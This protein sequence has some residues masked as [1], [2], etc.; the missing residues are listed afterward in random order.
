MERVIGT[1]GVK[2]LE[3]VN[4]VR[5]KWRVRWDAR[6][7]E[8]GSV[9]YMEEE[10]RY[11]PSREEIKAMIL[12][13]HDRC[14]EESILCGFVNDGVPVWLSRENQFNY[15]AACDL[16]FQSGGK[17][18]PVTFKF[19]TDDDPVY[20]EFNTLGELMDFHVRA[21]AHIQSALSD[22]WRRKD[23]LD[24]SPYGC[25]DD[26]PLNAGRP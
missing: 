23:A 5:D 16:A 11:K 25:Q 12:R 17:T 3:R 4:P 6:E 26:G 1:A 7:R 2:P 10:F 13:W 18:L 21:M 19:G 20:K 24:L 14:I 9:S 15:K 22:G 8:D